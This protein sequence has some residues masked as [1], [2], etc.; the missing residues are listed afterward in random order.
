MK[1][2][3]LDIDGVL[4]TKAS[5]KTDKLVAGVSYP[6]FYA[7]AVEALNWILQQTEAKII[8][9]SSWRNHYKLVKLM[10]IL[11]AEGVAG[12]VVGRTGGYPSIGRRDISPGRG[13]E[14]L[15]IVEARAED[16]DEYVILDDDV[17]DIDTVPELV[18]HIVHVADGFDK[19]G[20]TVQLAHEA[21]QILNGVY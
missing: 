11:A 9:S 10:K 19:E 14:I 2:I 5:Y 6:S 21:I 16:I 17:W 15:E 1:I 20:L 4:A 7:P 13:D 8:I 18:G 3:F 12:E